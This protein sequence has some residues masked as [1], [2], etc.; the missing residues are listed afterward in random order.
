MF[1]IIMGVNAKDDPMIWDALAN[2]GEIIF[3]NVLA[4]DD[5]RVYWIDKGGAPP[6]HGVNFA[7]EW[8]PGK[9]D[10]AGKEIPP[11]HKN[12][13]FTLDLS[14]LKNADPAIDDPKGLP[15]GGMIYGGRDSDTWVPVEESF[16]W[17]HGIITKGASLESETTA[18]TLGREGVRKFNPMSNLDFLSIPIGRYVAAC[19]AF[20]EGLS[21][22]PLIY[23]VN[24]FLKDKAGNFL[25]AKTHKKVWLKWMER[26]VHKEVE[27]RETPTGRIPL[28]EDLRDIFKAEL[29]EEYSESDYTKQFTLRVPENIAK[30]ERIITIYK[31]QVKDAPPLLFKVLEAQKERLIKAQER[32]GDYIAPGSFPVV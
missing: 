30:V 11:S 14:I 12:A 32:Y 27:A 18:A 15:I 22:P 6:S 25:N 21:Q 19:L 23:S 24:Y 29:G 31:T 13:R 3:S 2:P 17:E 1:G 4:T 16:D 20:G 9:K 10:S 7:G 8:T 26:R 5:G 28:Y